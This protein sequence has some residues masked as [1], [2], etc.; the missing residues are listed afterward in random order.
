[1]RRKRG[2]TD[3]RQ[4]VDDDEELDVIDGDLTKKPWDRASSELVGVGRLNEDIE[5]ILSGLIPSA[6]EG[7]IDALQRLIALSDLRGN[8]RVI[9]PILFIKNSDMERVLG[10]RCTEIDTFIIAFCV[11]SIGTWRGGRREL[12]AGLQGDVNLPLPMFE[13]PTRKRSLL[14]RIFGR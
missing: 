8:A 14:S 12:L 6:K 7:D 4:V 9:I 10:Q 5:D 13:E 3:D 1:M 11:A 2:K